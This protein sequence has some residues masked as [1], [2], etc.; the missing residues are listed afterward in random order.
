MRNES[1]KTFLIFA[2]ISENWC[3]PLILI[4]RKMRSSQLCWF[5]FLLQVFENYLIF[6]GIGLT[7]AQLFEI[8]VEEYRR[9]RVTWKFGHTI[10]VVYFKTWL[11][12]VW[13]RKL[14]GKVINCT[15]ALIAWSSQMGFDVW[16]PPDQ[17]LEKD[18]AIRVSILRKMKCFFASKGSHAGFQLL[19]ASSLGAGHF[20]GTNQHG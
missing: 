20:Q 6:C 4:V 16:L 18:D 1:L 9:N 10:F 14:S 11:L 8:S 13:D 2:I 17:S 3:F 15:P 7:N 5:H 12:S 19:D